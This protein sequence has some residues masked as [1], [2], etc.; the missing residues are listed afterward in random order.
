[1]PK[2]AK[3]RVSPGFLA[4]WLPVVLSQ[5]EAPAEALQL[6]KRKGGSICP[7]PCLL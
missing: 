6:K 3:D 5:W 2:D 4:S 1:M 7:T